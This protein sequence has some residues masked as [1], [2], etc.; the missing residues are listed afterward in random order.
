MKSSPDP[1]NSSSRLYLWHMAD[2]GEEV[3]V[4]IWKKS[5][6]R[7]ELMYG[8]N[9]IADDPTRI[10]G[11]R[12]VGYVGDQFVSPFGSHATAGAQ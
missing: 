5:A 4:R 2:A 9:A 1:A 10:G 8:Q 11:A 7:F 12:M 3:M 6:C